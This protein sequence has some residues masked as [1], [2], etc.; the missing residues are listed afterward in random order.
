M[1]EEHKKNLATSIERL[2]HNAEYNRA[3]AEYLE[4]LFKISHDTAILL[5]LL[6]SF[7]HMPVS[8]G[9]SGELLANIEKVTK[10]AA[11]EV[12][13]SKDDDSWRGDEE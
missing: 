6:R 5:V 7:T 1:I 3:L 2:E 4:Q 10:H 13:R 9:P 8:H 12:D 11:E